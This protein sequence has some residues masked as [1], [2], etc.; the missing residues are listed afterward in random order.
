MLQEYPDRQRAQAIVDGLTHG[1]DVCYNG[2]LRHVSRGS[3]NPP[4]PEFEH[5]I[6]NNLAAECAN[7]TIAGPFDSPPFPNFVCSP[8]FTIPKK[9]STKRRLIHH[10]SHPKHGISVNAGIAHLDV[11]LSSFDKGAAMV[12]EA[13]KGCWMCKVDIAAAYRCIPVRPQDFP[14][15]GMRWKGKYYFDKCLPF[16]LCS[17]CAIFEW[18][19]TAAE[20][21]VKKHGEPFIKW[22]IH[23]IDDFFLVSHDE[24]LAKQQLDSLLAIFRV[25]GLPVAPHKLEGPAQRL[26]FL[27]IEIDSNRME[28]RL[29]QDKLDTLSSTLD[30]WLS[31]TK[32]ETNKQEI[33][34]LV[35]QLQFASAVVRSGRSFLRRLIDQTKT[36]AKPLAAIPLTAQ[37]PMRL[38]LLWWRRF[39]RSWNGTAILLPPRPQQHSS[40]IRSDACDDG[41]GAVLHQDP[42]QPRWLHG[43]W[44]EEQLQVAFAQKRSSMPYLE[45]QAVVHAVSTWATLLAN[46]H[47]SVRCDCQPVVHA[48][49]PRAFVSKNA[50]LMSLIR[51]LLFITATHNIHLHVTHIAGSDNVLADAL[52]RAQVPVFKRLCPQARS[53]PDILVPSPTHDW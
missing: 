52:S 39:L 7:G 5:H 12:V 38:D 10:L 34:C 50:K 40:I 16:G 19:S 20:W 44:S 51:T 22:L 23:Y 13:G 27:G 28:A 14:L 35:G 31:D 9:G 1:V 25:L 32:T 6:T 30:E 37:S 46:S 33:Q 53:S 42:S 17:S 45:L 3:H 43:S 29:P 21:I 41:Y 4:D 15:L 8:L 48:L 2:P 11:C 18:F 47:V 36:D 26:T 49:Q 24:H